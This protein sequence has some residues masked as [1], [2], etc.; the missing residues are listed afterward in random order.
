MLKIA[1]DRIPEPRELFEASVLILTSI[2]SGTRRPVF[3]NVDRFL[4]LSLAL[5][6]ISF[7]SETFQYCIAAIA[8]C[9]VL[10]VIIPV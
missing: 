1:F 10:T 5:L 8:S 2:Y 7:A 4:L 9:S 3:D 6:R